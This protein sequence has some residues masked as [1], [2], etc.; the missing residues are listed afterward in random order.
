[1][2]RFSQSSQT[3]KLVETDMM[4]MPYTIEKKSQQLLT[5]KNLSDGG[6]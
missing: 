5:S 3:L 1:M 2:G 6:H 4:T